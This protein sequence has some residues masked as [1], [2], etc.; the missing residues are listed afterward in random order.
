MAF[1]PR[2]VERTFKYAGDEYTLVFDWE[3]FAAFEEETGL[4]MIDVVAADGGSR[5]ITRLAR[6]MLYGLKRY[7]PDL[8]LNHAGEM[9][10]DPAVQALLS[11]GLSASMPQPGDTDAGDTDREAGDTPPADPPKAAA[12]PRKRSAG[13][14]R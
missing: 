2:T 7:H 8:T 4:S 12:R 1:T 9:M 13:K 6:L 5:K 14:T 11:E 3:T 10:S